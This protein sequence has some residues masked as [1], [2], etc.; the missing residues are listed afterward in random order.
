MIS[1]D[2]LMMGFHFEGF[3]YL[4]ACTWVISTGA[5]VLKDTE[6]YAGIAHGKEFGIYQSCSVATLLNVFCLGAEKLKLI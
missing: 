2:D 3:E 1:G 4:Y 5:T 6:D